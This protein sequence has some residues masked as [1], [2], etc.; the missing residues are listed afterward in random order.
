MEGSGTTAKRCFGGG[1]GVVTVVSG[2]CLPFSLDLM[3]MAL[4]DTTS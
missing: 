4:P 2:D 3:S 1:E